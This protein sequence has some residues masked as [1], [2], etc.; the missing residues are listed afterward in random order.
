MIAEMMGGLEL[1]RVV[2]V[3]IQELE[4]V[5]SLEETHVHVHVPTRTPHPHIH[6][7]AA[8]AAASPGTIL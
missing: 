5:T 7:R 3:V 2:T 4:E 8:A 1:F 6:S